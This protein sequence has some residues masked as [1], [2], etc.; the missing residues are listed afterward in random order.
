M[1]GQRPSPEPVARGARL[2]AVAVGLLG[3]WQRCGH[4]L[5]MGRHP[6]LPVAIIL[7]VGHEASDIHTWAV[8]ARR[9]WSASRPDLHER[10]VG[11]SSE[12]LHLQ[13]L[14]RQSGRYAVVNDTAPAHCSPPRRVFRRRCNQRAR[15]SQ[16]GAAGME[17]STGWC[18]RKLKGVQ[19]TAGLLVVHL[20]FWRH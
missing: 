10:A 1:H 8:T 15:A 3:P 5:L 9:G 18:R 2:P 16:H 14:S 19:L 12:P 6:A 17:E 4:Q 11:P 7:C 13:R 20:V